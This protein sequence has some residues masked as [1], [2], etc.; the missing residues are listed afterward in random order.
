M[1]ETPVLTVAAIRQLASPEVFARGEEYYRRGA[2]LALVRRGDVLQAEVE[3]SSYAPY[4][5]HVTLGPGGIVAEDC[6]CPY[7]WG[8]ACKHVV[9]TLLAA[10]HEPERVE[11]R[12]PLATLL[13]DL[14]RDQLRGLVLALADRQPALDAAIEAQVQT[15]RAA[16]AAVPA[17]RA[18]PRQRQSPLDGAPYRRQVRAAL[19]SLDR[20]S[21]SE[22]YWH[23]GGVVDEVRAIANQARPFLEGGDGRSAL[24]ILEAVTDEYVEGWT[25]LD[26]SD[27][28][29]SDY[30]PEL[31]QLWAEALLTADLT[32]TERDAWAERFTDWAAELDD[33]GVEDAF[34]TAERAAVEGWD[35][36]NLQ[37]ILR[38]ES[39]SRPA[40]ASAPRRRRP[41]TDEDEAWDEDLDGAAPPWGDFILH[42]DDQ[43][44]LTVARLNVLERQGRNEE[45]LRLARAM[46]Q[47]RRYATMLVRLGRV[48]EA[49]EYSLTALQRTD[50]ALAVARALAE[51]G[52]VAEALRVAERGLTLDGWKDELARW[53]RDTA[54]AAGQPELALRAARVA[55]R[56]HV[57]LAD[58][59][60][61][62]ELAGPRWP[63]LRDE[64]L[65][66]VRQSRAQPQGQVEIFLHEGLIDEAIAVADAHAYYY[67]LVAQVAD[68]A[69]ASHPAW[70]MAVGKREAESII[71]AGR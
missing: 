67:Q 24:A 34:Y 51:A 23:V 27:G 2:V 16:P 39:P 47:R 41:S 8:G 13:A 45:Y 66:Q 3:G 21:G 59:E 46:D 63:A 35:E 43:D 52:A 65:A 30:F 18:G 49:V 62:R 31:D 37:R 17:G 9:A 4:Q 7:D 38:G 26:D 33:Y 61:V 15:L 1:A 48:A 68:A 57:S 44:A 55:L 11:E 53:T 14:D 64:V 20:M 25:E 50:E 10:L 5:V 69:I 60:A 58:Y 12:P 6:S 36:P 19:R 22:A 54:S 42:A 28:A 32:P 29:A 40:A 56:A 71:N 70:V